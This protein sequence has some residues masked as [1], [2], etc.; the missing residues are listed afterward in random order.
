[1]G[2][3]R[4]TNYIPDFANGTVNVEDSLHVSM[5]NIPG[6][7]IISKE[8]WYSY[9]RSPRQNVH[10]IASVDESTYVPSSPVK[11]GDHPVI[12][13][14]TNYACKNIYIFMG[15]SPE[16]FKDATYTTIFCNSIFWAAG[17]IP[18]SL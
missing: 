4:F 17:Q 14:N 5:K 3:I 12:W 15:H 11:M 16:L 10:V 18:K 2:G 6:K 1:M 7:F 8:E 9:D 13:T